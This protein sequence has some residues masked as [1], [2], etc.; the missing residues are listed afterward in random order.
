MY[1]KKMRSAGN[2]L[3]CFVVSISLFV[4]TVILNHQLHTY[5]ITHLQQHVGITTKQHSRVWYCGFAQVMAD[6]YWLSFSFYAEKLSA[7]DLVAWAEYI[8]LLDPHFNPVYRLSLVSLIKR[9]QKDLVLKILKKALESQH[10][11]DDWRF[12]FYGAY[13]YYFL[14]HD[15]QNTIACLNL[16]KQQPHSFGEVLKQDRM[17]PPQFLTRWHTAL[18]KK[19]R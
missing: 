14:G 12:Y 11:V 9:R 18:T 1:R 10:N 8:V 4:G 13:A 16:A 6:I 2:I 7:D 15:I 17:A 3:V 5:K 19:E